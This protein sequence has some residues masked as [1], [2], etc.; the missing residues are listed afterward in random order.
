MNCLVLSKYKRSHCNKMTDRL[1]IQFAT[2][3]VNFVP[4]PNAL[5]VAI[6]AMPIF[7]S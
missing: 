7:Y 6:K 3:H 1:K 2:L 5:A 4:A